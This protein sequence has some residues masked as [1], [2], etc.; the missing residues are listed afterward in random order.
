MWAETWGP[1]PRATQP[2][3]LRLC[4]SRFTALVERVMGIE[5]T[6]SAWKAEVL[7]LNYTRQLA[8]LQSPDLKPRRAKTRAP[9][10]APAMGPGHLQ[11]LIRTQSA[12]AGRGSTPPASWTGGGG[13]IRTF[14][15]INQQI[16]SLPPL[17]AWVPLRGRKPVIVR[18][19]PISVNKNA[20]RSRAC[21]KAMGGGQPPLAAMVWCRKRDLNPQPTAYKA[22]ALP[23]E[24]FRQRCGA[25]SPG[26]RTRVRAGF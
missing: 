13:R 6:S 5:P 23:V 10:A 1:R 19:A 15:G 12:F 2:S 24:L 7:P 20:H 9:C 17:A 3:P 22:V 8:R 16:Y 21:D 11:S 14:E 26:R 18:S 4:D 25:G